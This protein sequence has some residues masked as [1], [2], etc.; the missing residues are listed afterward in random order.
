MNELDRLQNELDR[1]SYTVAITGAGI[2]IAAGIPAMR[3]LNMSKM[4]YYLSIDY[5]Q[6]KPEQYYGIVKEC[7]L[8]PI[9]KNGPTVTHR[10]MAEME[11]KEKLQAVITTN[12]DGLHGL[13]GSR[14][15]AEIQGGFGQN[16]CMK[17]GKRLDDIQ[18]WNH[19]TA[20]RCSCGG[21]FCNYLVYSHIGVLDSAADQACEW[22][23]KAELILITGTV[24]NY[25]MVY[26]HCRRPDAKIVQI[27]PERTYFDRIADLNIRKKSDEV[28]SQIKL[29][30]LS[31]EEKTK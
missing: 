7:F 30:E 13:A 6:K 17:C 29:P 28:F 1:S 15:V 2:S 5:L 23:S 22:I 24:G 27:N 14:N 25:A 20:P 21:L 10:K 31:E 16:I 12:M 9:F 11:Q 18:I 3:N 8:D 4:R 19:G 26:W